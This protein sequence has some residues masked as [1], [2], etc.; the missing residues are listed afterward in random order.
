MAVAPRVEEEAAE[1]AV[2]V[3]V[4]EAV[5]EE[6]AAVSQAS[7]AN[8][9]PNLAAAQG[10]IVIS[11]TQQGPTIRAVVQVAF[12][13]TTR[14]NSS[15]SSSR[16]LKPSSSS[17]NRLNRAVECQMVVSGTRASNS[18][19]DLLTRQISSRRRDRVDTVPNAT[20]S[21]KVSARLTTAHNRWETTRE[22]QAWQPPSNNLKRRQAMQPS[23]PVTSFK[24]ASAPW[25]SASTAT[26]S[27]HK[28]NPS[29]SNERTM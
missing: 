15:S 23:A 4:A 1:V 13:T 24:A 7:L 27:V 2:V 19:M 20:N 25:S 9:P 3:E 29:S 14:I 16:T 6:V 22:S 17:I 28:R 26:F 11:S 8:S 18:N 5:A 21:L 10:Q 12:L